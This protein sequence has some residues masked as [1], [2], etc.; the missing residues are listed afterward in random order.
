MIK[1]LI[2]ALVAHNAL[3]KEQASW[4][5]HNAD[6]LSK[7]RA[8]Y[9]GV[10]KSLILGLLKGIGCGRIPLSERRGKIDIKG[11]H[12]LRLGFSFSID[13]WRGK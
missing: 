2:I 3:K 13:I 7:Y 8:V 6:Y 5:K 4:V 11:G 9:I 1:R 10:A 12:C